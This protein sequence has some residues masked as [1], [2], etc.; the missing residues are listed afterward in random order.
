MILSKSQ[1]N[2]VEWKVNALLMA[3]RQAQA[4]AKKEHPSSTIENRFSPWSPNRLQNNE[5][6]NYPETCPEGDEEELKEDQAATPEESSENEHIKSLE[7]KIADLKQELH[8]VRTEAF[9]TGYLQGKSETQESLQ[10]QYTLLDGYLRSLK[11]IKIDVS[12]FVTYIENLAFHIAKDV[13]CFAQEDVQYYQGI[14]NQA[15]DLIKPQTNQNISIHVNPEVIGF[16]SNR[17][18]NTGHY[19]DI[20]PDQNLNIGDIR[21]LCGH[22]EVEHISK[23]KLADIF[24][25][26]RQSNG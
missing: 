12:D 13:I 10:G 22:S 25:K 23:D 20:Y 4:F 21:I 14:F 1:D 7:S 11:D 2:S 9:E 19:F 18:E 17:L 6:A 16:I 5:P 15:V 3:G 8:R 24:S 26:L